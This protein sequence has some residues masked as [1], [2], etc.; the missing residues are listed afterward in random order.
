MSRTVHVEH[1]MGTVFSI[2]VRESRPGTAGPDAPARLAAALVSVVAL[3]HRLDALCSTYRP[4][5]EV[6]RLGRGELALADC[7]PD[8]RGAAELCEDARLNTNG[9]FDARAGIG[10]DPSGVVKGWAVERAAALLGQAGRPRHSVNGGGDVCVGLGP[11]PGRPWRI[12]ISDPLHAGRLLTA[13][14]LEEG[15]VAT[16]GTAERGGHVIDP[17]TGAP[18]RGLA[19]VTVVAPSLLQADVLATA[20]M[21]AGPRRAPDLLDGRPGVDWLLVTDDGRQRAGAGWAE[22]TR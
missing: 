2:D 22:R 17:R 9:W 14:R 15:G 5:S 10:F 20:A 4:D 6:S 1:A 8:V 11:E 3:L 13:V 21:A 19:A 7:A 18:A 16:S 12:G